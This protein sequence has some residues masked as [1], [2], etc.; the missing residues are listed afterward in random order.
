MK[1]YIKSDLKLIKYIQSAELKYCKIRYSIYFREFYNYELRM[2]I[3]KNNY[4]FIKDLK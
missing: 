2:D 3:A 1:I 4:L